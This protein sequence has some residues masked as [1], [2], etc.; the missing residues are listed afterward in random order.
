MSMTAH[1][2]GYFCHNHC[3]ATVVELSFCREASSALT[4]LLSD[5]GFEAVKQLRAAIIT[6]RLCL[7]YKSNPTAA[8]IAFCWRKSQW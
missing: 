7:V 1:W 3:F 4:L 6:F 5:S 8:A 2:L